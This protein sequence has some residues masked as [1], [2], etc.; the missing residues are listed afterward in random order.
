MHFYILHT[1]SFSG[2]LIKGQAYKYQSIQFAP[3][4][5]NKSGNCAASIKG[6]QH[7]NIFVH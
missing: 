1:K 6:W 4:V 7:L 5:I 2:F 3:M